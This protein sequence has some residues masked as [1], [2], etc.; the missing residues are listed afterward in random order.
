MDRILS[1]PDRLRLRHIL[2]LALLCRLT[3][4][5][6]ILFT[7]PGGFWLYDSNE[8]WNLA[9]NISEYGEYSRNAQPPLQPD[10][11]RTPLYPLFILPTVFFDPSGQTIPVLQIL[12][13]IISCWLLYK[14]VLRLTRQYRYARGAALVYALHV[15]ALVMTSYVLT[16]SVF[17]LLFLWFTWMLLLYM[18]EPA[19]KRAALAGLIAGLCVMCKPVAFV[20]VF[21]VVL[22]IL[23]TQRINARSLL[24]CICFSLAFYAVQFPWMY[25]NKQVY[26]H[27]FNSILGEH[28]LFGYHACHIYSKANGIDYFEGK[29][30]LLDRFYSNIR[31][32]PYEHPYEYAKLIEWESY[33]ILWANKGLFLKEH[34]KECFRFFVQPLRGYIR[35]QL[36]KH[37]YTPFVVNTLLVWQVLVQALLYLLTFYYIVLV[38]LKKRKAN[39]F[40]FFLL[41]L[42]LLFC[43]FNTMPY[44]D[45]RMRFPF[46][47]WIIITAMV[48]LYIIRNGKQP[49][50]P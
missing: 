7:N 38:L 24:A 19:S 44:T 35:F 41:A 12:L 47:G 28:L 46:D 17:L 21:P 9:Y 45:A 15:P 23:I 8:Y 3:W 43:Q 30:I 40:L 11:F 29:E 48:S 49:I 36:G 37:S 27:Y 18:Q 26:G 50:N 22:F 6:L 4:Y 14:I 1:L 20:L 33:R 25:R 34:L 13:D 39:A 5:L 31:F 16:E 10:Y 2:V 42:L 32:N